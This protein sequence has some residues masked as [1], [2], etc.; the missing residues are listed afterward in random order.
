MIL[1]L[2]ALVVLIISILNIIYDIVIF[3]F[4]LS[5]FIIEIFIS[6]FF[7]F[8]INFCC[9]KKWNVAS[10]I[11]AFILLYLYRIKKP[12]LMRLIQGQEK[13]NNYL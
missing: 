6:I 12:I 11:F 10:W 13:E 4:H 3:K 8:L 7:V 9:S 1:C 5:V 2:P